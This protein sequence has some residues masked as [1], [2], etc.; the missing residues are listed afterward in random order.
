MSMALMARVKVLESQNE[1]LREQIA[2]LSEAIELLKKAA[3]VIEVKTPINGEIKRGP[4]RPRK[5]F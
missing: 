4:G 5:Y 3:P 2:D 1:I